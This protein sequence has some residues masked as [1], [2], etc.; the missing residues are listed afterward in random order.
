MTF[1]RMRAVNATQLKFLLGHHHLD[2]LFVV[3]LA[4][5]INIRFAN[6]FIDFLVRELL[7]KVGHNVTQLGSRD[8]TVSVL[9]KDL[10]GFKDLF[11]GVGVLHLASHHCQELGEVNG[12]TAVGINL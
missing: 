6:H 1:K 8:E 5:A 2:K 11:F 12:T 3:D 7:T 10:E 9:V 4:V